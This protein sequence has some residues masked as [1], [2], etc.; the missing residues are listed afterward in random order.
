MSP[1]HHAPGHIHFTVPP[2]HSPIVSSCRHVTRRPCHWATIPPCHLPHRPTVPPA[3]PSHRGT[4]HTVSPCHLP[5]PPTE[6]PAT[7]SH[8]PTCHHHA[9]TVSP[10]HLVR[11]RDSVPSSYRHVTF[12]TS[13]YRRTPTH[14][15]YF[16]THLTF[17]NNTSVP[18]D[19]VCFFFTLWSVAKHSHDL[20]NGFFRRSMGF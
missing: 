1:W 10:W 12:D 6:P 17:V 14:L 4:C 8:R 2:F 11:H 7:P 9:A 5:H 19:T 16:T 18:S 15:A 13:A 3:T 20:F